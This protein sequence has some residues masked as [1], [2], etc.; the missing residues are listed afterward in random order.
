MLPLDDKTAARIP[1]PRF[2][3]TSDLMVHPIG[4]C[5][6]LVAI[7]YPSSPQDRHGAAR[8]YTVKP[9]VYCGFEA[10]ATTYSALAD[11]GIS[12]DTHLLIQFNQS[13]P[14][15]LED[16]RRPPKPSGMSG[17]GVWLL[18]DVLTPITADNLPKLVGIIIEARRPPLNV[19]IA[20]RAT[21]ILNI[22]AGAYPA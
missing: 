13:R 14:V 6:S 9:S 12:P 21:V 15:D 22:A 20:V 16:D 3:S 10:S 1:M 11:D 5:R 8:E 17:G 2:L 19:M 18:G 7:G 4:A